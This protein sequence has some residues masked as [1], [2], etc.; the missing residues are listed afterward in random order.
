MYPGKVM[1]DKPLIQRRCYFNSQCNVTVIHQ[2][3]FTLIKQVNVSTQ[4][5]DYNALA[6]CT[7]NPTIRVR[8][9]Y[10]NM[11]ITNVTMLGYAIIDIADIFTCQLYHVCNTYVYH[12]ILQVQYILQIESTKQIAIHQQSLLIEDQVFSAVTIAFTLNAHVDDTK[13]HLNTLMQYQQWLIPMLESLHILNL[14]F[15]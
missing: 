5:L 6:I 11:R 13:H 15:L 2:V 10:F 14:K 9:Q 4:L 12:R 3:L 7:Y 1:V 8:R